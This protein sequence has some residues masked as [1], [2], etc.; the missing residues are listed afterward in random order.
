MAVKL[1]PMF[2]LLQANVSGP[3]LCCQPSHL[4]N[5]RMMMRLDAGFWRY[6]RRNLINNNIWIQQQ[7]VVQ[8]LWPAMQLL[9]GING[10]DRKVLVGPP[11][12]VLVATPTNTHPRTVCPSRPQLSGCWQNSRAGWHWGRGGGRRRWRRW[13][14]SSPAAPRAPPTP[15]GWACDELPGVVSLSKR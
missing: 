13:R 12:V 3:N 4:M 5:F 7:F 10:D 15:T 6:N 2:T 11:P 14:W 1:P 9:V 8:F